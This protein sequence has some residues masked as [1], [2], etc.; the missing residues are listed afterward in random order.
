MPLSRLSPRSSRT[1]VARQKTN[2]RA[3]TDS[4]RHL[5][6]WAAI[7]KT[8]EELD[9]WDRQ[10]QQ[11]DSLFNRHIAPREYKLTQAVSDVTAQLIKHFSQGELDIPDQSLLG[12]WITENLNSLQDHPFAD[13]DQTSLLGT[14]WVALLNN[15]GPV[16]SQLAKLARK[17]NFSTCDQPG[18]DESNMSADYDQSPEFQEQ[19]NT[20]DPKQHQYTQTDQ[21]SA[22]GG[23]GDEEQQGADSTEKTIEAPIEDTVKSLEEKLS[24]ERLFRQLA[25]VLHPDRE[26]DEEAKAAK[27][28]LMSECLKAR[29]AKDIQ[30]LLTLYCEHVG[31][32]PD[33]LN[34]NSHSE[35]VSA[36]ETQ[37][38][39]LQLELRDKR[40][41]DPLHT[42]IIE[43]YSSATSSDSKQRINN[44][45][46]SLDDEISAAERLLRKLNEHD[47]LLDALDE[48]R[49]IEQ[50]RMAINEMTGM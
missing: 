15:D 47:G 11:V 14:Q 43:R 12:L 20:G 2:T 13:R 26:Q 46:Q 28:V 1:H 7:R 34:D 39:L 50:D 23:D 21:N 29:Q 37:L 3:Q 9:Q 17:N 30:A 41:G 27:H 44:H 32:L 6:L 16:E 25:K 36:L 19:E 22:V 49:M 5:H 18:V 48:R 8:R 24:V 31:E 45:A 42:M 38:K 35:L 40:F 4:Q 33:D 10:A